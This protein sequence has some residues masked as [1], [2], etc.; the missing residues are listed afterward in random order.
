ML[1][2]LKAGECGSLEPQNLCIIIYHPYPHPHLGR[3]HHHHHH[4]HPRRRHHYLLSW[5]AMGEKF[6]GCSSP[7]VA[8][9]CT[10]SGNCYGTA[11]RNSNESTQQDR[12]IWCDL[13]PTT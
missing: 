4:H 12:V 7:K 1:N 8:L 5:D 13:V 6:R 2:L 3:H 10:S 9:G 11:D